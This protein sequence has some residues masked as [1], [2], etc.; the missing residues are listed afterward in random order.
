MLPDVRLSAV[1]VA[2]MSL[3]INLLAL[4]G[5]IYMLQVYDRV[6]TSQ[7]VPTLVA[8]SVLVAGLYAALGV[9]DVIR[10]QILLRIGV[11]FDAV[12][13]PQA[14][15]D[16]VRRQLEGKAPHE[17]VQSVRDVDSVRN[18]FASAGPVTIADLP[19]TPI[20]LVFVSLLNPWLG[21]ATVFGMLVLV[22]LAICTEVASRQVEAG[23]HGSAQARAMELE[24]ALRNHEVLAAMG[25]MPE[26]SDR[27]LRRHS[28]VIAGQRRAG[29]VVV[30][31]GGVSK[32]TRLMLQSG[33]LGL[34]A[35]LALQGELSLGAIVA[36]SIASA[37]ALAPVEQAIVGWRALSEA[38]SSLARLA[39][40]ADRI[41][42]DQ[43]RVSLPL[44]H[45]S[46]SLVQASLVAPSSHR[47]VLSSISLE[48][49][50]GQG[51][52]VIGSSGAGK[53]SLA[54]L[55][56]GVWQVTHGS[57]RLDGAALDQW[58]PSERGRFIGYLPQSIELFPATVAENIARLEDKPNGPEVI[59]AAEAAGLHKLIL[60]LPHGYDTRI[61][62]GGIVLSTGQRQLLGLARAL[63][64]RPFL[65]VLDEPNANL[66]QEGEAALIG[67]IEGIRARGGIAVVIAHRRSV[68]G[69]LDTIAVL[70][71]GRLTA[72]GPKAEVLRKLAG[73]IDDA[74]LTAKVA[75]I[76]AG[77]G[78]RRT[79][80]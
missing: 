46:V 41:S 53:S 9:L 70:D 26:A 38:R 68:L 27:F 30:A 71:A 18:F 55:L 72:F 20:Y 76:D 14:F 39:S 2:A 58:D 78:N 23:V 73:R 48:L 77:V 16:V 37:R 10:G 40:L 33:V 35:Y 17:A 45:S 4:S 60:E 47:V 63:Y 80:L 49:R 22:I 7:S 8:L 74:A 65:V 66:D 42:A 1:A 62:P 61:G 29:D 24:A 64:G 21:V 6:L 31:L 59:L 3:V 44:P 69:A 15:G 51:V 13:M 67:A 5:A 50:A 57:L 11:R 79:S 12:K 32:V 34:G 43:Q 54:R 28:D 52:A 75:S 36:A 25:M 19:W 56:A